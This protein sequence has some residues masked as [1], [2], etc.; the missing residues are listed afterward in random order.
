MFKYFLRKCSF[1]KITKDVIDV[2]TYNKILKHNCDLQKRLIDALEEKN[3]LQKL[4]S[5]HTRALRPLW[6]LPS[7]GAFV[8]SETSTDKNIIIDDGSDSNVDS[9]PV[10]DNGKELRD[11]FNDEVNHRASAPKG[12]IS[13]HEERKILFNYENLVNKLYYDAVRDVNRD[14]YN[15]RP[16]YI[17][18]RS[19]INEYYIFDKNIIGVR[20]SDDKFDIVSKRPSLDAIIT[21]IIDIG[22]IDIY[23]RGK[24]YEIK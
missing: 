20:I 9:E 6:G 18:T 17:G 5:N 4:A 19:L 13:R 8:S 15:L 21:E 16:L 22:G 14:N 12:M 7:G 1:C 23:G 3:A 11:M 24:S 10:K 2:E